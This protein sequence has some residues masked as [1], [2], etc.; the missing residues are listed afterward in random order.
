MGKKY[1]PTDSDFHLQKATSLE[2]VAEIE[3]SLEDPAAVRQMVYKIVIIIVI[4][5]LCYQ[6]VNFQASFY[7]LIWVLFLNSGLKLGMD[8]LTVTDVN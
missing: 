2:E 1:E 5:I 7:K 8:L 6:S 4:Q 3:E